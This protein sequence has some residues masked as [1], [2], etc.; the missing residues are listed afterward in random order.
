M[1]L[2]RCAGKDSVRMKKS[3]RADE[4]DTVVCKMVYRA[5]DC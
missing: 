3:C 5:V 1:V 2:V 4:D